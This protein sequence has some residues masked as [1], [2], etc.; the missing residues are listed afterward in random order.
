MNGEETDAAAAESLWEMV[1]ALTISGS[2]DGSAEGDALLTLRAVNESGASGVF[3]FHEYD[4][5]SYLAVCP[6][7]S[8]VLTPAD[9]VDNL[10]R[11]LRQ[12]S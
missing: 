1:C 11:N 7:G 2:A 10:I 6:N 5:D 4:A 9:S 12:L 8:A 3:T